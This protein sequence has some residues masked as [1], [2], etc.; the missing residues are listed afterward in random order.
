[1]TKKE[2]KRLTIC[3]TQEEYRYLRKV[4]GQEG[5]SMF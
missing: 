5:I 1:M 4:A 3:M 2:W